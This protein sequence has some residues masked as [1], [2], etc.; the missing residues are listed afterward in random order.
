MQI[1]WLA[2][3]QSLLAAGQGGGLRGRGV[4]HKDHAARTHSLPARCPSLTLFSPLS[5]SR[6][7]SLLQ[8]P[9]FIETDTRLL[10]CST[11]REDLSPSESYPS[12]FA[13]P[14]QVC[15]PQPVSIFLSCQARSSRPNNMRTL[16][17]NNRR[18]WEARLTTSRSIFFCSCVSGVCFSIADADPSP[19]CPTSFLFRASSACS[20]FRNATAASRPAGQMSKPSFRAHQHPARARRSTTSAYRLPGRPAVDDVPVHQVPD[21][22]RRREVRATSIRLSTPQPGGGGR[23]EKVV[24]VEQQRNRG[25]FGGGNLAREETQPPDSQIEG[26]RKRWTS[27][28][29]EGQ[30]LSE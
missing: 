14:A 12:A 30:G 19:A 5:N 23:E 4:K 6:L 16:F 27:F 15:L 25:H 10:D 1:R 7:L 26:R 11:A 17:P 9:T 20:S 18:G 21:W 29:G 2:V 13:S 24:I 8:P 3:P 22:G 28:E